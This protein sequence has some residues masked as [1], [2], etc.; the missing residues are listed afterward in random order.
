MY[1]N[2][3]MMTSFAIHHTCPIHAHIR[4][5]T[6]VHHKE[7]AKNADGIPVEIGYQQAADD[8]MRYL[9]VGYNGIGARLCRLTPASIMMF[10]LLATTGD[11]DAFVVRIDNVRL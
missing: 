3:V 10:E 11:Y 5:V 9:W 6:H 8:N 2:N 4:I 1:V 7:Y